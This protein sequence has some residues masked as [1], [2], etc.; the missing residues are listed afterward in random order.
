M[1]EA[2]SKPT[3][4]LVLIESIIVLFVFGVSL[5]RLFGMTLRTK[6]LNMFY[7]GLFLT[8]TIWLLFV[9]YPVGALNPGSAVRYRANFFGFLS[10][11]FYYCYLKSMQSTLPFWHLKPRSLVKN[12]SG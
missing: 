4:L 2:F 10:V 12:D 5:A 9:N 11:L 7:M 1:D 3:H 6:T 8:V